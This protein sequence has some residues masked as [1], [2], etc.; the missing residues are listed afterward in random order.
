MLFWEHLESWKWF[1]L[2]C[3]FL[4]GTVMFT[5]F[6]LCWHLSDA[7]KDCVRRTLKNILEFLSRH[8]IELPVQL[9]EEQHTCSFRAALRDAA[10]QNTWKY[11]PLRLLS[12]HYCFFDALGD[13]ELFTLLWCGY[14][15]DKNT[16]AVLFRT[17]AWDG[18]LSYAVKSSLSLVNLVH[19][20]ARM[21]PS[22]TQRLSQGGTAGRDG[23]DPGRTVPRSRYTGFVYFCIHIKWLQG[24]S[25][26]CVKLNKRLF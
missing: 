20:A 24:D 10:R 4:R 26:R 9:H 3:W 8:P 23:A 21:R 12:K 6:H 13:G 19:A 5:V 16:L 2:G 15:T 18:R 1:L 22:S 11:L 14:L 7:A 17:L 25:R